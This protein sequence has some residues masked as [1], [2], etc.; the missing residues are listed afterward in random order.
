[1]R[2]R[3]KY[4]RTRRTR[5]RYTMRRKSYRRRTRSVGYAVKSRTS[6]EVKFFTYIDY[7]KAVP[8]TE[9]LT[10]T[11]DLLGTTTFAGDIISNITQG[12]ADTNRIGDKIYVK[13]IDFK[14]CIK[15]CLQNNQWQPMDFLYRVLIHTCRVGAGGYVI[16]YWRG[17]YRIPVTHAWPNRANYN[18]Y[19]DKIVRSISTSGQSPVPATYPSPVPSPAPAGSPISSNYK[20]LRFRIPIGRQVTFATNGTVKEQR[21][22]ITFNVLGYGMRDDQ[23]RAGW[24]TACMDYSYR[25][26]FTDL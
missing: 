14:V 2:A 8:N 19:Y 3:L 24:Q 17:T 5:R 15:P 18:T 23:D 22:V 16:G 26:Y 20:M 10:A 1:M 12:T 21:D 25:I 7:N 11:S 6:P 13:Y 4:R 9:T